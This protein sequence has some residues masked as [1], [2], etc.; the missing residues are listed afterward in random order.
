VK[1]IGFVF[2]Y[3]SGATLNRIVSMINV[4][5]NYEIH[6][7]GPINNLDNYSN[8]EKQKNIFFHEISLSSIKKSN[9]FLRYIKEWIYSFKCSKKINSLNC[10]VEIISVPFISLIITSKLFKNNSK[11]ILDI[12]DLVWEYYDENQFTNKVIFIILKK[13]HL[14]FLK[15]YTNITLSNFFELEKL[16]LDLPYNNKLVISN[17]I[18][19]NKFNQVQKNKEISKVSN[20]IIITYI[21]NVGIA[22]NLWS[23]ID[24]VKDFKIFEFHIVGGGND[25]TSIS[26]KIHKNKIKNVKL[27]GRVFER[28]VVD[29]YTKSHFLYAKLESKY[30][31][32]IPS[33]LY[34]YL[35]TGKPIIY[36]GSGASVEFLKEFDNIFVIKDN[37]KDIYNFLNICHKINFIKKSKKNIYLIK[38]NFIREKISLKLLD[39]IEN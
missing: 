27:I 18:S 36:S 35:S 19:Q 8:L 14:F 29:Y 3:K 28:D 31:T 37:K 16:N 7:V 22:Q 23:F 34:E 38:K 39:I 26:K 10:D 2:T 32:A 4:L 13:V 21:G 15:E 12:R 33:K 5:N 24:V 17:G 6:L 30:T 11:K 20:K 1:K 25:F 9:L